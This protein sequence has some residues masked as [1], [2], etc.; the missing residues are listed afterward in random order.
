MTVK[1]RIA[2]VIVA[3][4][5]AVPACSTGQKLSPSSAANKPRPAGSAAVEAANGSSLRVSGDHLVDEAGNT[6]QLRGVNVSGTQ[7]ACAGGYG[8]FDGPSDDA[9]ISAM[10]S[11]N[12]NAVRVPLNEA[13]WLGSKTVK[14]KYAGSNYQ[15]AIQAYVDRIRAHGL[16]VI[17]TLAWAAPGTKRTNDS[18][19]MP[20]R[21]HS[22]AFWAGVATAFGN[23][24]GVLFDLFN[25]PFPDHNRDSVAAW[26]CVRD[27][28]KCPGI[29]YAAAGSQ[30]LLDSVRGHGASNVV[31]IGGPQYAGTLSRWL[32]YAPSDPLHQLAASV[33]IYFGTPSAPDWSPCY[34]ESCWQSQ[35]RPLA[36]DVPIVIGE[37]GEHD[38]SFDLVNGN[39]ESPP[40]PSL[41]D[42]ADG[43]GVSYLA[44]AWF[45]GSC[46]DE[47]SLIKDYNGQPTPY[48]SG[49]RAHLLPLVKPA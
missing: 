34:T 39:A 18:A 31:L 14:A 44:W 43:E 26:R 13:C 46:A 47:P 21:D 37:F 5:F 7:Y 45:V 15:Q 11:W 12:I 20:D 6:V 29:S 16:Y 22:P 8:I 19:A 17:L 1:R 10:T 41:L 25:E 38:C 24:G 48:G 3:V 33:H 42:W 27:G 28:G 36:A 2:M 32:A 4:L 23:D 30:Q 35:I 40:Q 49:Y 9:A